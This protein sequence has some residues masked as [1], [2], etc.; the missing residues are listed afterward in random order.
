[1]Y[2]TE[3]SSKIGEYIGKLIAR[4][5]NAFLFQNKDLR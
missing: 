2:R 5:Y 4:K 1:M 3:E